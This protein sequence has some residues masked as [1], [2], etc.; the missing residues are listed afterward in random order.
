MYEAFLGEPEKTFF[1]GHSY[2]GN[3]LGCA[4]ALAN[5]EIF[6]KEKTLAQVRKKSRILQTLLKPLAEL[7]IVGNVRQCGLM[8]GIELVKKQGNP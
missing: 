6:K 8:A 1:H 4:A 3:A 7:P 2:T 5:L